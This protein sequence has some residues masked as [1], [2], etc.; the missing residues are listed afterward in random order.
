MFIILQSIYFPLTQTYKFDVIK[1]SLREFSSTFDLRYSC[2]V[3]KYREHI[4]RIIPY[5]LDRFAKPIRRTGRF[6][7]NVLQV[8]R[9]ADT[10]NC[11]NC[12]YI[13]MDS[14]RTLGCMFEQFSRCR[15]CIRH[16]ATHATSTC[17]TRHVNMFYTRIYVV[18]I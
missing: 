12:R 11:E 4:V 1:R 18:L 14:R 9:V 2:N 5:T 10:I 7:I 16:A 13:R 15:Y 3:R 17:I 8:Q 6:M